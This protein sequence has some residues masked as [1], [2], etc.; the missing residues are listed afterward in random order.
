MKIVH[1]F[2]LYKQDHTTNIIK[3]NECLQFQLKGQ[4]HIYVKH[5]STHHLLKV[6]ALMKKV[7]I[8]SPVVSEQPEQLCHSPPLTEASG[9]NATAAAQLWCY[10]GILVSIIHPSMTLYGCLQLKYVAT[11]HGL[12]ISSHLFVAYSYYPPFQIITQG[13]QLRPTKKPKLIVMLI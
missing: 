2:C 13:L 8:D 7:S 10:S 6:N 4:L 12:Y 11:L 3:N 1:P 5:I 9:S